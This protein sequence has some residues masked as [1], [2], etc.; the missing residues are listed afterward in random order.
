MTETENSGTQGADTPPDRLNGNPGNRY[1]DQAA[2]E[3]GIGVRFNGVEK[4]NVEEYCVS[5]GWV[6]VPVGRARDRHGD[7]MT[8]KLSGQVVVYYRDQG[9]PDASA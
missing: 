6:R 5:E 7:L 9:P 2:F 8:V 1:Y 4:N 3:R